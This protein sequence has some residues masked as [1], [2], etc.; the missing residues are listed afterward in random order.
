ML[1]RA[2]SRNSQKRQILTLFL[3][4]LSCFMNSKG[5]RVPGHLWVE[6]HST[7]E[8][9]GAGW[10]AGH[11]GMGLGGLDYGLL[12]TLCLPCG[13][14]LLFS[15]AIS[16]AREKNSSLY[17]CTSVLWGLN[18]KMNVAMN[19]VHLQTNGLALPPPAVSCPLL[20]APFVHFYEL[21]HAH[22]LAHTGNP[23]H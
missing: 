14:R 4:I 21:K 13:P 10:G 11:Q 8:P 6:K 7:S 15:T 16:T 9:R 20:I 19:S 2:P 1:Q 3:W 12:Q 22:T 18:K 5:N 17:F 23:A